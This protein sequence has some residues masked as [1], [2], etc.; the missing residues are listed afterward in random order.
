MSVI[1]IILITAAI[2]VA[3]VGFTIYALAPTVRTVSD[4]PALN[5]FINKQLKIKT[6]AYVLSVEDGQFTF[7]KNILTTQTDYRGLKVIELKPGDEIIIREF[8]THRSNIGSGFTH[9]YALGQVLKDSTSTSFEYDLGSV[10]PELY[11]EPP[12][13]LPLTL[14]QDANDKRIEFKKSK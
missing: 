1:K 13:V 9:L 14:W 3:I 11:S 4:E 10:E 2:A 5:P 12:T 8:K 6:A 7:N